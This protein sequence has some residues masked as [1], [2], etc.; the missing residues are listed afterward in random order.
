MSGPGRKRAVSPSRQKRSDV[1]CIWCKE[2]HSRYREK[3]CREAASEATSQVP[4][5][6]VRSTEA[7]KR[8]GRSLDGA[9]RAVS[10]AQVSAEPVSSRTPISSQD[11]AAQ[12]FTSETESHSANTDSSAESSTHDL[13]APDLTDGLDG[14]RP[15]HERPALMRI[16]EDWQPVY[17]EEELEDVTVD[18]E[19]DLDS[20]HGD[21][22]MT[23][24]QYIEL[25][26]KEELYDEGID[27][28]LEL[29]DLCYA[30]VLKE[31]Q[32][33]ESDLDDAARDILRHYAFKVKHHLTDRAWK[34][35]PTTFRKEDIASIK[36]ARAKIA[37]LSHFRP[38]LYDCCVD[39][40]AAFTGPHAALEHCPVCKKDRYAGAGPNRRPRKR[41]RYL[42]IIP[43][44]E[45]LA[46]SRSA[47]EKRTYRAHGHKPEDDKIKDYMD[48]EHYQHLQR[49]N[50][51]IDG[52]V[53][54]HR[55]FQNPRDTALGISTDGFAPFRKRT[56]TCWPL[57]AFDLNL[58]PE[59]RSHIEH[60]ISL[61]VVPGPKKPKDMDS[62][63]WPFVEEMLQLAVGVRAY[64]VL[65]GEVF[66][67]RAY[68]ILIFGD[69]PAMSLIMRMKGANGFS[70][71]RMCSIT[72]V[73][74][75]S[76]TAN[77]AFYFPLDRSN[78]PAVLADPTAPRTFDPAALPLRTHEQMIA[79]GR[80]VQAADAAGSTGLRD[81]LARKYGV[82]GV[83][84]LACL[85]SV[86]LAKCCPYDFM[87]LIWENLV[88]NLVLHW[89]AA[90]KGLGQGTGS[91]HIKK[92][93]WDAIGA[94]A[95]ASGSTIPGCFGARPPNF[96]AEKMSSTADTW[97]FW[98]LYLA[99]IQLDRQFKEKKYYDHFVQLVR[100][101]HLC[102]QFEI[103]RS[104]V[105][106]IRQGFIEWVKKYEE[107]Y[108]QH[109][110]DRVS[111]CPLTVHALLHIA[112]MILIAG[113]V[114]VYWAFAME[115]YCGIIRPAI[116]SKK[117]PYAS[118]DRGVLETAQLC[119]IGL[120][121][122]A[123][124]SLQV[125]DRRLVRSDRKGSLRVGNYN[126]TL[127]PPSP[128][129]RPE[130][131]LVNKILKA[132]G[133]RYQLSKKP[134]ALKKLVATSHITQ[135]SSVRI[136]DGDLIY[137]YSMLTETQ[138]AERR[139]ATYIRYELLVDQR[140]R[141]RNE[142]NAVYERETYF[143]RL[144]HLFCVRV[145]ADPAA[146][147]L[148]AETILLAGVTPCKIT[149]KH[150]VLDIHVYKDESPTEEVVDL[151]C[152]MCLV[153]R[154][155]YLKRYWAIIDRSGSLARAVY[156]PED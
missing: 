35:L 9:P 64:D 45:A 22:D 97:S 101:L 57:I 127:L 143:G 2:H 135:Y 39:S 90:F 49:T 111:A 123:Q 95:A 76:N 13:M 5:L 62:F 114:W 153:G 141:D 107:F 147:V 37:E 30:W 140:P 11:K 43:R 16:P 77:T 150:D 31:C 8:I 68:L 133:T 98:T 14:L 52:K 145:P 116:R 130:A 132:L 86:D 70:P 83:P 134:Q 63:L 10:A 36:T 92:D 26:E 91:Y 117:H 1:F 138:R 46:G 67:M 29:E 6:S 142:A 120:L 139:D 74:D 129:T 113:P 82:K 23:Q 109:N 89:T 42:P 151:D 54:P 103:K 156:E 104:E 108:Y 149:N 128:T 87:H 75:P 102:L 148:E 53:L 48:S 125:L 78:H 69:I 18:G 115:R 25:D 146:G 47:A 66:A 122:N 121:Y 19:V 118:L 73:H 58:P 12:P 126:Y 152:I 3:K 50:V 137:A 124:E 100:L 28:F 17:E 44:L 110:P 40:C 88:K 59:V 112:D 20:E 21:D 131:S 84:L 15:A 24:E 7:V 105:E 38:V 27:P 61:G 33:E 93:V 85:P 4:R 106:E 79:Q 80:E 41:F 32:F 96:A 60:I 136:D 51:I 56:S 99:P 119:Q 155:R 72:G 34:D 81:E 144:Q 55:Y 65:S 154:V 71:C 94:A